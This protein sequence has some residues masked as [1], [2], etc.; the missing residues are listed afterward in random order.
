MAP[1]VVG[2]DRTLALAAAEKL[3]AKQQD[4]KRATKG[5]KHEKADISSGDDSSTYSDDESEANTGK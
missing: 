1:T 2:W 3:L 4:K 5:R